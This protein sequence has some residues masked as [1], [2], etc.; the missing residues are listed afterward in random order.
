MIADSHSSNLLPL[1]PG[2]NYSLHIKSECSESLQK[3]RASQHVSTEKGLIYAVTLLCYQ[4]AISAGPQGFLVMQCTL[5]WCTNRSGCACQ[6]C[7]QC[8][9][10]CA[11][12]TLPPPTSQSLPNAHSWL[13]ARDSPLWPLLPHLTIIHGEKFSLRCKPII[14][15]IVHRQRSIILLSLNLVQLRF[16]SK[17]IVFVQRRAEFSLCFG[18]HS[19]QV[20]NT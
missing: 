2:P 17:E 6:A 20:N 7:M 5:L 16:H 3:G 13:E 9:N 14:H 18:V 12:S 15:S 8:T 19:F 10:C 1:L 11:A 4:L